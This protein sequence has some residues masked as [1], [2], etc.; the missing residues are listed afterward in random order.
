MAVFFG[1]K[2]TSEKLLEG[3][4][5]GSVCNLLGNYKFT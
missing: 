2:S 5:I 3:F 4:G 1:V